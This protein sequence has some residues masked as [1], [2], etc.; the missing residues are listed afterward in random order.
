LSLEFANFYNGASINY[1][2]LTVIIGH[3]YFS[4]I[5]LELTQIFDCETLIAQKMS[6]PHIAILKM[7]SGFICIV[8]DSEVNNVASI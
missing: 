1:N 2:Q 5:S 8:D 4:Q 3:K 6:V 7:I